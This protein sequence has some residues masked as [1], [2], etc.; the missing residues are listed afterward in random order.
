MTAMPMAED[1]HTITRL[2]LEWRSGNKDAAARVMELVYR[3]LH[4][5]ASRQ[6]RRERGEHT[7]QTTALVHEAYIRLC[8]VAPIEWHDRAHFFAVAAQQLRRVLVDYARRFRSEK[9]GGGKVCAT[10][11]DSDNAVWPLDERLLAVDGALQ[12]L[13]TLDRRAAKVIELRFFGG[14]TE[15]EAAEALGISITT[16]KRDWDFARSWLAVQLG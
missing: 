1:S 11:F 16:L 8:G 3:E 6:M 7:L 12:K 5:M 13:E 14:L 2:L 10:L 4:Q 15:T 9:R